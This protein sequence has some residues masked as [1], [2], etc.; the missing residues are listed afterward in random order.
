M[1]YLPFFPVLKVTTV[2]LL[3][4]D[5]LLFLRPFP[6]PDA[7]IRV[8]NANV[9][10]NVA[11]TLEANYSCLTVYHNALLCLQHMK[12]N[13]TEKPLIFVAALRLSFDE[14]S[15]NA[16]IHYYGGRFMLAAPRELFASRPVGMIP[17]GAFPLDATRIFAT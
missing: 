4:P 2:F 6:T 10:P 5:P 14:C 11:F 3:H 15:M 16:F 7:N 8:I 13:Y 9:R 1:P 12:N 17:K